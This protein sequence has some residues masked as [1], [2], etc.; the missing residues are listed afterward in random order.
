MVIPFQT[1]SLWPQRAGCASCAAKH[2][3]G[4]AEI[5]LG[6]C[7]CREAAEGQQLLQKLPVKLSFP[8]NFDVFPVGVGFLIQLIKTSLAIWYEKLEI[9][10][11]CQHQQEDSATF[12]MEPSQLMLLAVSANL[13]RCPGL[14]IRWSLSV[15]QRSLV[16]LV[17]HFY[18][19]RKL[20]THFQISG[21]LAFSRQMRRSSTE[22][23]GQNIEV[24]FQQGLPA[25][26]VREHNSI[27][28]PKSAV[29]AVPL[30][31]PDQQTPRS[32][33]WEISGREILFWHGNIEII[34]YLKM[35]YFCLK[36]F[37]GLPHYCAQ[38]L[39]CHRARSVPQ[40]RS[41]L[42]TA[43]AQEIWNRTKTVTSKLIW[44]GFVWFPWKMIWSFGKH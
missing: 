2:V 32:E 28:R 25:H 43:G 40:R 10:C 42:R 24:A 4:I 35:N 23:E 29:Q 37:L 18:Q 31:Y 1:A 14:Y 27:F 21:Q 17:N 7:L 16:F 6:R 19:F 12:L 38:V 26:A 11:I 20:E 41:R 34:L 9:V 22:L 39:W 13:C 44:N 15:L 3:R 5:R 30:R 36:I 33:R 8:W